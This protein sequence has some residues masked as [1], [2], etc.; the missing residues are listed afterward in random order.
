MIS[1]TIIK[2]K[3]FWIEERKDNCCICLFLSLQNHKNSTIC[4]KEVSSKVSAFDI[5]HRFLFA[6]QIQCQ[7]LLEYRGQHKLEFCKKYLCDLRIA[8]IFF[9]PVLYL[10]YLGP[11]LSKTRNICINKINIR[12]KSEWRCHGWYKNVKLLHL[13]KQ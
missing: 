3:E 9:C 1:E 5:L 10:H 8:I 11:E 2:I 4:R 7:K 6:K 13:I 12:L